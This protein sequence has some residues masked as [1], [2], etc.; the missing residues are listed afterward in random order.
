M[1]VAVRAWPGQEGWRVATAAA[2]AGGRAGRPAAGRGLGLV[3]RRR[4]AWGGGAAAAAA[5]RPSHAGRQGGRVAADAADATARARQR[6]DI[7]GAACAAAAA[8]TPGAAG[9]AIAV[10][11]I[12]VTP[13][14]TAGS[15]GGRRRA[16][17]GPAGRLQARRR[18][19][20]RRRGVVRHWKRGVVEEAGK[21]GCP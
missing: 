17:R 2:A 8:A 9:G 1:A 12:A 3:V 4:V 5:G 16:G 7:R 11:S 13:A 18:G 20:R 6:V 21:R 14:A 10:G 19:R 15:P